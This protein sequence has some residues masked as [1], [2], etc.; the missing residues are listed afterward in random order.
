MT[1]VPDSNRAPTPATVRLGSGRTVPAYVAAAPSGY[2]RYLPAHGGIVPACAGHVVGERPSAA[3]VGY[4][5]VGVV[6]AI[7]A[8]QQAATERASP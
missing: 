3:V 4:D 1:F 8:L 5:V 6:L 7:L 2:E